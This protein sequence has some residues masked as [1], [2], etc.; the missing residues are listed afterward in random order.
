METSKSS[1][2]IKKQLLITIVATLFAF[3]GWAAIEVSENDRQSEQLN[4]AGASQDTF[5]DHKG[6]ERRRQK[7][8]G[9]LPMGR[10]LDDL[11]V[12][13]NQ[14]DTVREILRE[15]RDQM[16][17]LHSS[18]EDRIDAEH[19]AT[20]AATRERLS[21]VLSGEQLARYDEMTERRKLTMHKVMRQ[22]N[23]Q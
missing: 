11:G 19:T 7:R 6:D 4:S 8:R 12:N 14:R 1:S 20:K 13:D 9:P 23:A 17:A 18:V 16:H 3:N 21:T 5:G 22:S 10:L 15:E 2:N